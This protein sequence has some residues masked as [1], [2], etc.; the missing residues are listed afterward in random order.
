MTQLTGN[1]NLYSNALPMPGAEILVAQEYEPPEGPIETALAAIWADVLRVSRVGRHDNFFTLGGRSL[2]AVQVAARARQALDVEIGISDLFA[3]PSLADLART[4]ESARQSRLPAITRAQRRERAPLSFAQRGLWFLAQ[5]EGGSEAYYVPLRVRL[6]GELNVAAMRQAL[7]RIVARHEALRTTFAVAEGEPEQ[8]I[9]PAE[10]SGFHLFEQDLRLHNDAP[11]ELERVIADEVSR[12]FDLEN[13]PLIR[14]RLI[15]LGEHEHV[16]LISMH[17]IVS[18]G[19]SIGVFF[20]ELGVLYEAYAKGGQDRFPELGVQYADYAVWQRESI[21]G[22]LLRQAQYWSKNLEGAPELL[23]VPADHVRPARQDYTGGALPVRL[24][25]SLTTELKELSARHGTTLYMT[26][27]AGWAV[28]LSRLSG[29]Q[30]LLIGTP[31]ANRGRVEIENLIGNFV[32]MLALRVDLS[33]RPTV[34]EIL[35]RVK[36]QAIAA[37][38]HQDIP[39]E[40]VLELLQPVRSLAHTPVFQV[41]FT[42]LEGL[43]SRPQL[44]GL[45]TGPLQLSP[46]TVSKFDL[47][48]LIQESEGGIEGAL[49]YATGLFKQETVERYLGYFTRL[50]E[51]MVSDE[52]EAVDCLPLL[53]EAERRKVLHHWNQTDAEI[54]D[55]C[56]HQLFEAQVENLPD[57]VAMASADQQLSFGELNA[58]AN[59]LA[60]YLRNLGVGPETRVGVCLE[61]SVEM[62]VVM[63]AILK[64][65]GVYVPLDAE[66]PG[67]RL[68]LMIEDAEVGI[69]VTQTRLRN[70]L[71]TQAT[72]F[73][74][75]VCVDED[76]KAIE[77][78]S[79]ENIGHTIDSSQLAYVMYTSGS[80]GR[81]KGVMVSHRNVVR[82]VRSTNYVAFNPSLVIGHVSNV[83]F[84]A[85]TFEVW[86]ALLN[87]SRLAVISKMNVLEAEIFR[88]QLEELQVSTLFLTTALFQQCVRSCR[89]IFAAMD[90]VLFG[91]ELC[92][93]ECVRRAVE[94]EGPR[95]VVHV[96]GPTETTTFAS[97]LALKK[98]EERKAVPI[99]TPIGNT[100]IFIV[101]GELHLVGVGVP[102]EICVG[103]LGVARGYANRPEMTAEQF[104][105]NAFSP[106]ERLYRTGDLGRW[107]E[108]GTVEFVGRRDE[109]VKIRGYRIELGEVE[110]ALREQAGV[111]EAV[112][113]A[114]VK[115]N[116][117]KQLVGYVVSAKGARL[118]AA[119]A[120]EAVAKKLPEYMVPVVVL[121]DELPLTTNG[122]VD[123]RKLPSPEEALGDRTEEYVAPRNKTEAILAEVWGEALGLEQVGVE[124]NFF[125]LGGDSILSVRIVGRARERG[126]EFSVQDLFE[127]Q[128]VRALARTTRQVGGEESIRT[129]PFELVGEEVR[130]R[131][132]EDVEDAYP[133]SRLQAGMLFHS[134]Y[135]PEGGV[136]HDVISYRLGLPYEARMFQRAVDRLTQRHG[137]LRTS[138]DMASF[139]EPM[140]LLHRSVDLRVVEGDWRG[141]SEAAQ[142][143]EL[144]EFVDRECKKGFGWEHAP[145]MRIYVHRLSADEFQCSLSFHHAIMDGWSEASMITELIEDYERRLAGDT[146]EQPPLGV[147]YRDYIALE[148]RALASEESIA[149]WKQLLEGHTVTPVPLKD[150]RPNAGERPGQG[151]TAQEIAL[152]EHTQQRLQQLAREMSAPLKTVLLAAHMKALQLLSGQPDVTTGVVINGRPE[153]EGGEQVLGL[154]LNTVPFRQRT[155]CDGWRSQIRETFS[156]E[157]RIMPHRRYPMVDLREQIGGEALFQTAFN[158]V[159]FHVYKEMERDGQNK[160]K[161]I[162]GRDWYARTNFDF[163]VDFEVSASTGKLWGAVQCDTG[164]MSADALRRVA[165]Y[166]A[167]VLAGMTEDRTGYLWPQEER[168]Q[169]AEWNRTELEIPVGCAHELFE[170]QVR[171]TPEAISL[172]YEGQHL[173]YAEL[174]RRANQL[175]HYLRKL[176][177]KPDMRVAICVER[178]L[179]MVVGLLA[180]MKAG[181]AYVPLDPA[182]PRERSRY[183]LED[184]RPAVLLTQRQLKELFGGIPESLPVLNLPDPSAAW[185]NQPDS[186]PERSSN[187]LTPEH[188]AYMIYTSGSTGTPKGVMIGHHALV[189]QIMALRN[190]YQICNEDRILQFASFAFDMSVEEIFGALGSGA[191]L[192]LRSDAWLVGAR[193]F[194]KLCETNRVSVANLPTLFWQQLVLESDTTIPRSLRQVMIGGEAVGRAALDAWF[195]HKGPRPRL[196]NAYGPTEVTVNATIREVN[197]EGQ[198]WRSIGR[199][200]ANTQAYVLDKWMDPVPAGVPGELCLGGVGLARGYWGRGDLSAERFVP[201]GLSGREDERLYRTGD[202]VRWLPD[203]SLEYLSRIDQQVKVRGFRIELGE[204]ET[205][206][207]GHRKVREAVVI[208]REDVEGEK[209]L[210]AYYTE[211]EGWEGSVGAQELRAWMG[212]KLPEYL[213]PAAYV[214]TNGLPLTEGGKLDPKRLPAPGPDAYGVREYEEPVGETEQAV[215][216]IWSEVLNVEPIGRHDNFFALGGHSLLAMQTIARL[217][218]RLGVEI[219]GDGLFARPVLAPLAEWIIDQQ[220]AAFDADDLENTLKLI[221]ES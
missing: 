57:A 53:A 182:Y 93:P 147:S 103:G 211:R 31:V 150:W 219:G 12:K 65:G 23:E 16:L 125:E 117:D 151:I 96:Y 3:M 49:E 199:P 88:G 76:R 92:D 143:E 159:H 101:D 5:M 186:N 142:E 79:A 25:E 177:V 54:P 188:L 162:R 184:C 51:G 89:G 210:V 106:A 207:L 43:E 34:G 99:G 128:T 33:G 216:A 4:V 83:V 56:I 91:G 109:Q 141:K 86:G 205:A 9:A 198:C 194:W 26:L 190:R 209:R 167:R 24:S 10:E 8:R 64:A 98:I 17:H 1:E 46:H 40:Q 201:D 195:K 181:G 20:K 164:I 52:N 44:P 138:I 204:I 108:D 37:Q 127:H 85:S 175:A 104:V 2:L 163:C 155:Q 213:V 189:N 27:L 47:A 119:E 170:E 200:I 6:Q 67:E 149:F 153:V 19:W 158:Y 111:K 63:L 187:G 50:L 82:L 196:F 41:T 129:A 29:Q 132:A 214:R 114:R 77:K 203:G 84:D 145:L 74:L 168:D 115:D 81:P 69:L 172:E 139:R 160:R 110:A 13:G 134:D 42:W 66:Y 38:Q 36:R 180:V 45:V 35:Q 152:G 191:S 192:V 148:R 18:D 32:N 212:E 174:N 121:L 173:T 137:I 154:F 97:Y 118:T 135:A 58:R 87:G 55:G 217:R 48:L 90:Q 22:E 133:L 197:H 193:E 176:G 146:R 156:A 144:A 126:L 11:A 136:Y 70:H 112:A 107:R 73:V 169:L 100:K 102:G 30:D 208:A 130:S 80:T 185:R 75:V 165:G 206:L 61:R 105:P 157:Q 220:L 15:R 14:G 72:Q 178:S 59:Q 131:V 21:S 218:Q 221:Q 94:E 202:L 71:S 122:K 78:E 183:V 140:Q 7:D 113:V 62:V 120:R 166:Y 60:R 179:E 123:R 161:L 68:V 215:A 124:E 171:K 95:E 28:L 39:F 116:G